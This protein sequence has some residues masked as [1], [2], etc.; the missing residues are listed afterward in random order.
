MADELVLMFG[1]MRDDSRSCHG[2]DVR[3]AARAP[4]ASAGGP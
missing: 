1:L 2:A 3:H 4:V